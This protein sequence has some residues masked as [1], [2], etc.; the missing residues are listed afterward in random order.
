MLKY[1]VPGSVKTRLTPA[2]TEAEAA[3][4]YGCFIKDLFPRVAALECAETFGAYAPL[5]GAEDG[6]EDDKESFAALLGADAALIAQEGSSL[7]ERIANLFA[8]LFKRGYER[9]VIIGSDS[10]DLPGEYIEEAFALLADTEVVLGPALDGG[11]YLVALKRS[12]PRLFD[13]IEWSTARVLDQTLARARDAGAECRLLKPWH[14]IDTP[15]DLRILKSNPMTPE[16]SRFIEALS[17][18]G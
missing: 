16:S 3:A 17:T 6:G 13:S 2:L 9:V 7:G 4:L 8:A 14:D 11:Y 12:M 5:A 1:P 10:P 15:E 18:R